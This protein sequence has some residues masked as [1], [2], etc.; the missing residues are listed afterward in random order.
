MSDAWTSWRNYISKL[1]SQASVKFVWNRIRKIKGKESTNSI[2]HLS[3]NDRDVTSHREIANALADNFS[4]NSPSAFS[5]DAFI[6]VCCKSEKKNINFS[7][8]NVEV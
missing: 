4:H 7:S 5:T 8:E 1:N 6:S 2:H 3:V